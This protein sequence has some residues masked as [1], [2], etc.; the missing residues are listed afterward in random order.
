MFGKSIFFFYKALLFGLSAYLVIPRAEF[1]KFFIFGFFFGGIGDIIVIVILSNLNLI[2]YK[3]MGPFSIWGLFSFW[4]PIA[5]L[6]A[7]MLFFYFLPVRKKFFYPY[8]LGFALFAHM[9]G[10]VLEKLGLYQYMG[11]YIYYAPIVFIIWFSLAAYVY[12]KSGR[13]S[14]NSN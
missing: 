13:I 6:F 5:W 1:K 12:L 9:V 8:I 2:A 7:F 11:T 14:L 3:N 4:T 10:L